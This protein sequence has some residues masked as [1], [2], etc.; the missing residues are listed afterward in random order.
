MT[1][2]LKSIIKKRKKGKKIIESRRRRIEDLATI[3][4]VTMA[5]RIKN[6]TSTIIE[7]KG[8]IIKK[9]IEIS[10][11]N[12]TKYLSNKWKRSKR[13]SFRD[14]QGRD[15]HF[16]IQSPRKLLRKGKNKNKN[17]K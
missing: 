4:V 15:Q 7:E 17:N 13:N 2:K 8:K 1:K 11:N 9:I 5:T 3:K 12:R 16:S 6:I 10:I 14:R